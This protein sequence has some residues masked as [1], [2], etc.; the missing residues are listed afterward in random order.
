MALIAKCLSEAINSTVLSVHVCMLYVSISL[1]HM[2]WLHGT[3]YTFVS[4]THTHTHTHSLTHT[5]HTH[6]HTPTHS[7]MMV[8]KTSTQLKV[9]CTS[10]TS[11]ATSTCLWARWVMWLSR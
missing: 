11:R 8:G 5:H 6:T 10:V 3:G 7:F 9:S 4:H 1:G 2:Y